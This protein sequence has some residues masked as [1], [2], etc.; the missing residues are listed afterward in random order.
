MDATVLKISNATN[1]LFDDY[2]IG[3]IMNKNLLIRN[4]ALMRNI[5]KYSMYNQLM[6]PEVGM[7]YN[8]Y[9]HVLNRPS[10]I[11]AINGVIGYN[12]AL[13][14]DALLGNKGETVADRF[15]SQ[16]YTPNS[17]A[18]REK[19]TTGKSKSN[20]GKSDSNQEH[21][22]ATLKKIIY[23]TN[24]NSIERSGGD[25]AL[26]EVMKVVNQIFDPTNQYVPEEMYNFSST[27]SDND[28][29]QGMSID[30]PY[31][32][33][34]WKELWGHTRTA[35]A[36]DTDNRFV[37]TY[38]EGKLIN[39][40]DVSLAE[41]QN[42]PD[43]LTV[44]WMTEE[45]DYKATNN[46]PGSLL[47]KTN[48]LFHDGKIGSLIARFYAMEQTPDG[49]DVAYL[50][51]GRNLRKAVGKHKNTGYDNPYCRVW[52]IHNEY[53]KMTDLIRPRMDD[54]TGGFATLERIQ[55]PYGYGLRPANGA[56]RL[57]DMSVLKPNG[58]V[59]FAP[60]QDENGNLD[61]ES[62][63]KCM[64]SIENLAWKDIQLASSTSRSYKSGESNVV[65]NTQL[66]AGG[67]LSPE[68]VGPNGGRIMW[69]PPYNLRFSED[70]TTNWNS[71][72]FIG[73]GEDIYS[74]VNTTRGGSLSFTLLIDH[75]SVINKWKGANPDTNSVAN[76]EK[77]LRFFAGCDELGEETADQAQNPGSQKVTQEL[78]APKVNPR[79]TAELREIKAFVFFPNNY[80]G[81]DDP[82]DEF[83]DYL[84]NANSGDGKS[85]APY[86]K[87]ASV[88]V[89][90]SPISGPGQIWYYKVDDGLVPEK[91]VR[92]EKGGSYYIR[93]E[94]GK[95]ESQVGESIGNNHDTRSFKLNAFNESALNTN[96]VGA[97]MRSANF[98]T[99][100][101]KYG[102]DF[103]S[104]AD[105]YD[106]INNGS[107]S[108]NSLS[109]L[110]NTDQIKNIYKVEVR[111][112][113]SSHGHVESNNSLCRRRADSVMAWI[114][115]RKPSIDSD[116]FVVTTTR[117]VGLDAGN[118]D[119]SSL[120][121]KLARS[122]EVIFYIT[123]NMEGAK[124][125]QM[126]KE[127][128]E[129]AGSKNQDTTTN[130]Y[131]RMNQ[132]KQLDALKES[133]RN[134]YQA[135]ITRNREREIY[136][137]EY[138]YF[139]ELYE[140]DSFIKSRIIE[141]INYF[142]PAYHSITPEGFNARL[143]FLHQCTR[144]GPTA[145]ASDLNSTSKDTGVGN[146]AFGRA[147]YCILRIGDFYNT[148]I[149][150]ESMTINYDNANGVQWDLNPEGVGVQPMMAEVTIR[151]KFLGGTDISGPIE[152]LQNAVSFNYYSNASV[153][154]RRA[155]YRGAFIDHQ[156]E[157]VGA[158]GNPV[159][160]WDART[161]GRETTKSE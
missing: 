8:I 57:S 14:D 36:R 123:Q 39:V 73:R 16:P 82:S 30:R 103:F 140:T 15:F 45:E 29:F 149:M 107:T 77:I 99:S 144:Q 34:T 142:D 114:K 143:T 1:T 147:P 35:D 46:K 85:S 151:F 153:Y 138:T 125:N 55:S 4:I 41:N 133:N 98:I 49:N 105:L 52:T 53:S 100:D 54:E 109:T 68:Q 157:G 72:T 91:L 136:D 31:I 141:K 17:K 122:V 108:H 161:Q 75:P 12:H 115:S 106:V 148:K 22:D 117:V 128:E 116:K 24:S 97:K 60:H 129:Y 127:F 9:E 28:T 25:I 145:A 84:Y 78:E 26:G 150:I 139:R 21:R 74:Y 110:L 64:F 81:Y 87:T 118:H 70:V 137:N 79:E 160:H 159:Y 61:L 62:I 83:A 131:L 10:D 42:I 121:A 69:F 2:Q 120:D 96:S 71:N 111:G 155:D 92:F 40:S 11:G 38:S 130:N 5:G 3:N 20:D 43:H 47:Q 89:L 126:V 66:V 112:Y 33:T 119:V 113:A 23:T 59:N 124:F 93:R 44:G 67:T 146:L 13:D 51:R 154:D 90:N 19:K 94:N 56:S 134:M 76:E 65:E 6:F 102:E 156:N 80:S 158:D 32:M 27:P 58:F 132:Q 50:S 37:N 86:E 48:K 135:V 95:I 101:E 63:K 18:L 152:R 104:F 7:A 88:S